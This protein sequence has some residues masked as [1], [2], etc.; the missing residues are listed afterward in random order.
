MTAS[1][2]VAK[3]LSRWTAFAAIPGIVWSALEMYLLTLG[4]SQMLFFSI[5][6]TMPLLVL[7]VVVGVV[8]LTIWSV[9]ALIASFLP[10]YR[11]RIGIPRNIQIAFSALGALH[12]ALLVAY[13]QWAPSSM[14]ISLCLVGLA[15][16]ISLLFLSAR[17]LKK[18]V[19]HDD[20]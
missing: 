12:L 16:I 8:A 19:P 18:A 3:Q 6:H 4:G 14:R 5:V 15:T 7:V 1:P 9:E 2:S 13:D 11:A 17:H 20:T 10:T